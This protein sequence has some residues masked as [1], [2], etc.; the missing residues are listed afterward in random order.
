MVVSEHAVNEFDFLLRLLDHPKFFWVLLLFLGPHGIWVYVHFNGEARKR[1]DQAAEAHSRV[2]EL[3]P[4]ENINL[5]EQIREKIE[6]EGK[7]IERIREMVGDLGSKGPMRVTTLLE[8]IQ[9]TQR[10]IRTL[11]YNK[12]GTV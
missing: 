5:L 8:E 7:Q 11:L 4:R 1:R 3:N 6:T 10:E 2:V 9:T 12:Q